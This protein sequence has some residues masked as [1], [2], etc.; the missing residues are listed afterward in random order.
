M[1]GAIRDI[2]VCIVRYGPEPLSSMETFIGA[3]VER[4]PA[5]VKVLYGVDTFYDGMTGSPLETGLPE[6]LLKN[7]VDVLLAEYGITGVLVMNACAAVRIPLVVHFHGFDAYRRDILER[8]GEKYR[9]LFNHASAIIAVSRAMEKQLMDLGAPRGKIF[10]NACGVDPSFFSGAEPGQ[11]PPLFVA[12]GRFVEKKAPH[13]TIM[14]FKKVLEEVPESQLVMIGGGPMLDSCL[15]LSEMMKIKDKVEFKGVCSQEEIAATLRV[16]RA[17]VQHS[18]QAPDGDSEGTPVAI[19]EAGAAGLPVVS[20]AHAGIPDIVIH[21]E[22]GYLVTE[23][24][25][26]AMAHYMIRLAQDPVLAGRMGRA[27]A[28]RVSSR[29]SMNVSIDSLWRIIRQPFCKQFS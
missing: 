24:D 8:F 5:N 27:G 14:S 23:R 17:F 4:I 21:G 18:I 12:V 9:Q 19:M 16:A 10:Y 28:Q 2:T 11:A 20:T 15:K 7:G 25:V 1:T 6:F 3:H 26:G 13:L 29:F 22:T